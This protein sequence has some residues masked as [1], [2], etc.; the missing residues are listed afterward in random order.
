M[1]REHRA[2]LSQ[3]L[4]FIRSATT[5]ARTPHPGRRPIETGIEHPIS[6]ILEALLPP[7]QETAAQ[8]QGGGL[9]AA[10][11]TLGFH[12]RPALM[13]EIGKRVA[14]ATTKTIEDPSRNT[15]LPMSPSRSARI[16]RAQASGD[17]RRSRWRVSGFLSTFMTSQPEHL[18]DPAP[19]PGLDGAGNLQGACAGERAGFDLF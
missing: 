9:H 17:A 19:P 7:P 3:P 14:N 15:C 4:D 2:E 6:R 10:H 8:G 11:R 5:A 13:A 16:L 18:T 12:P 1:W